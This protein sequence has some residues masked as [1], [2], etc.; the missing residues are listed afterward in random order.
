MLC[1]AN[2]PASVWQNSGCKIEISGRLAAKLRFSLSMKSFSERRVASHWIFLL[3]QYEWNE[4]KKRKCK[5]AWKLCYD[6]GGGGYPLTSCFNHWCARLMV[7][8]HAEMGLRHAL[9]TIFS[10]QT[11]LVPKEIMCC[12]KVMEFTSS[13]AFLIEIQL[14]KSG[15]T[16]T[17]TNKRLRFAH[18]HHIS[19]A[20]ENAQGRVQ[21]G[22]P[23]SRH[24]PITTSR[25][26][27]H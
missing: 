12:M 4:W 16:S 19:P 10:H 6:A 26:F 15:S 14:A 5:N 21:Q 2:L 17:Q 25:N 11:V 9:M 23:A 27:S 8:S 22:R 18:R 7:H 1:N 20:A 13:Y 3:P 24:F